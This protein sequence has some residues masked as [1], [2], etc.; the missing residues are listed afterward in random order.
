MPKNRG[1]AQYERMGVNN[2]SKTDPSFDYWVLKT[3]REQSDGHTAGGTMP[4]LTKDEWQ[5]LHY[6]SNGNLPRTYLEWILPMGWVELYIVAGIDDEK[7]EQIVAE[8]WG[9]A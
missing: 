2:L 5:G 8:S 3:M 6:W 7:I 4:K 9:W 1:L